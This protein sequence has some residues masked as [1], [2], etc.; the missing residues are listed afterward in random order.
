LANIRS[1]TRPALQNCLY[2]AHYAV[3]NTPPS[4][5]LCFGRAVRG[6]DGIYP[7]IQAVVSGIAPDVAPLNATH[8]TIDKRNRSVA[9]AEAVRDLTGGE[10]RQLAEISGASQRSDADFLNELIKQNMLD[11]L[12][13]RRAGKTSR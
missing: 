13:L 9:L 7:G 11:I 5:L 4:H 2:A 10:L 12:V 8:S 6:Q 1:N 3:M